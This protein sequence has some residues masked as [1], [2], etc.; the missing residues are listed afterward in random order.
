MWLSWLV[1][2]ECPYD[3]FVLFL[4]LK[5]CSKGV[6]TASYINKI[7]NKQYIRSKM[8]ADREQT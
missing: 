7:F 5:I 4:F 2:Y 1:M 8:L 6:M 3:V